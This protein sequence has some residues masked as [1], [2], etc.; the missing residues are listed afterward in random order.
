MILTKNIYAKSGKA[1][2]FFLLLVLACLVP[3]FPSLADSFE[4]GTPVMALPA[5]S[6]ANVSPGLMADSSVAGRDVAGGGKSYII[7]A[8]EIP[9]FI[10]LLNGCARIIS[11]DDEENGKK[12][13]DTS[14]SNFTEHV[15]EGP[16]GF[17]LDDFS[18]NQFMHP[19]Q[20]AVYHNLARSA[21]LGYWESAAYTF[22]G[23]FL[24]ETGG[25][26]TSPSFNDQIASG[27]AG[28]FFGEPLHRMASHLLE[29]EKPSVWRE[30]FAAGISPPLGFNR[31][32]FGDRF[33]PVFASRN[34]ATLWRLRLGASLGRFFD[35]NGSIPVE[36][37]DA[38]LDFSMAYGLPGKPGYEYKRPFDYFHF[39]V[40][41]S[42]NTD[43]PV[44]NVMVRG[45]LAGRKYE[46]GD[47]YKGIWGLYG[48]YDYISPEIFRVSSTAFSL[49]TTFRWRPAQSLTLQGSVLG[50][51]GYGA[52]GTIAGAGERNYHYGVAPQ[53]LVALR[54]ILGDRAMLDATGRAYYISD[55][56]GTEPG[57][58][59]IVRWNSGLTVRVYGRHAAGIQYIASSRDA[60]YPDRTDAHQT[61]GTLSLV[62]TLLGK[63]GF[64]VVE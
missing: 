50:G 34:P 17:D 28:S 47:S 64:G 54:L 55:L 29:G 24:W 58:E 44:E 36:R 35:Q 27:I 53:G 12:V 41:A 2:R 22:V 3:F 25:E 56:G 32:M 51:V 42:G 49:G 19:Y 23:S 40:T 31:L 33:K 13:Y 20:G 45:L 6:S 37:T 15:A 11:P 14:F 18:T 46:A 52:A 7:P 38:T 59:N 26:T 21:G 4:S 39:E 62:Y 43:N 10:L 1:F 48:G 8:L 9:G 60:Y 5:E 57:R 16:W 61:T 30:F 63:E